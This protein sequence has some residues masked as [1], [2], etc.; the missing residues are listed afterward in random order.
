MKKTN[1]LYL[2][3]SRSFSILLLLFFIC[4]LLV[5]AQKTERYEFSSRHMGTTFRIVLYTQ[6]QT[7]ADSASQAAFEKV[8]ELNS[9]L[10]DYDPNS[11]L[12]RLSRT[13]GR[14]TAV[15]VSEPLFKTLAFAQKVARQ[16]DGAFDVTVGP[17]VQLWRQMN[18]QM[19]PELPS[20]E[21][22]SKTGSGVGYQNLKLNRQ[23]QSVLLAQKNMQLDL[24]GIAKGYAVDEA[25]KV[26]REH[27]INAV[28]VDGGGDIALGDPPPGRMGWNIEVLTHDSSGVRDKIM[29]SLSN[30]AVATSGDL[31]QHVEIDGTRY[32][33]IID[34]RTGLG[35]TDRRQVTIIA[36]DGITAD[37]YASAAS[38][39]QPQSALDL[40]E[41][42]QDIALFMEQN[43]P[44]GIRQWMS[45]EFRVLFETKAN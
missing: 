10:S 15:V 27:G 37:S 28:L 25:L 44:D 4:P 23:T 43:E 12:N 38:V 11:E 6:S 30:K 31:Y 22:L 3:S 36:P 2:F 39:L 19:Q 40:I 33:H 17:Y 5:T 42:M 16:T 14:D 26:L 1:V 34:P 45:N 35:L 24:G 18:R 9:I 7:L 13:S 20:K 41:N 8:E 21:L 32:S 29:L